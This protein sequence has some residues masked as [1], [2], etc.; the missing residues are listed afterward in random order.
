MVFR[1]IERDLSALKRW[2]PPTGFLASRNSF[3]FVCNHDKYCYFYLKDFVLNSETLYFLYSFKLYSQRGH[4]SGGNM[5]L[6][7]KNKN[8][9]T[10]AS[11]FMLA[12]PHGGNHPRLMSSYYFDDPSQGPPQDSNG[13]I[14]SREIDSNGTCTKGWVCEHR[15]P[16]IANM[17]RFRA[18]TDKTAVIGF[19]NIAE[20]QI[21]FCRGRKG[22]VAIN[23]S[24]QDL[25]A[26][27]NACLPNG[28]YCDV[29]S[30]DKVDGKCTGTSV[31]VNSGKA[32][33][34]ILSDSL[35]FLAIHVDSKLST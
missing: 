30:G 31:A 19:T 14:I 20:N 18:V 34:E 17:V 23:N 15:W 9:F 1:K 11:A 4:G 21:S 26:T 2:G 35:G 16:E 5:I 7:Y 6:S 8:L 3:V 10:M 29:I 24:E 27:V 33:I 28:V 12:H 32:H 13:N 22:F 25:I